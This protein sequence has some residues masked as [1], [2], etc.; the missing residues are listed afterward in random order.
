MRPVTDHN[1]IKCTLSCVDKEQKGGQEKKDMYKHPISKFN[2][3]ETD[4]EEVVKQLNDI[5]W[6]KLLNPRVAR[7]DFNKI[8]REAIEEAALKAKVPQYNKRGVRASDEIVEKMVK[9]PIK[10]HVQL[11]SSNTERNTDRENIK[12]R[13]QE[14]ETDIIHC[15]S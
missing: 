6:E 5:D 10:L 14:F 11:G 12:K 4:D 2:F 7:E 3:D 15:L 13:I 1:L 9:Q 8:F